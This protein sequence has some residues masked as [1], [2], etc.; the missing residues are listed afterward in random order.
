MAVLILWG[1]VVFTC[2]IPTV[3]IIYIA[4]TV[5]VDPVVWYFVIVGPDD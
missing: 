3:D 2:K 1:V 4:V 5:V